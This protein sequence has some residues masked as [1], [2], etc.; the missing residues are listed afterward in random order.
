MKTYNNKPIFLLSLEDQDEGIFTISLVN[1]PAMELPLFCFNKETGY[2]F[3]IQDEM[4]HNIISCIA[5]VDYPILRVTE[6]GNPFYVLFN[7]E[8]T[9]SLCQKLMTNGF[10]QA[11]SLDHNGELIQ[12]IQLQEVFIKD[13][14]KGIN[15]IGYDDAADGSLFGIWH[16]T[17]DNLWNDCLS[18]KFGGV[19]LESTFRLEQ[20]S[21]KKIKNKFSMAN[22]IKEMLKNILMQFN[23]LSTNVADL[24]WEEDSELEVGMNVFVEDAEGN[25]QPAPD[26]EYISDENVI[27]VAEGKVTEI[28]EKEAEPAKEEPKND[29]PA[30][31]PAKEEMAEEDPKKEE[32]AQEEPQTEPEEN[33]DEKDAKIAELESRVADLESKL[34]ELVAKIAEIAQAP[35]AQPVVEEFENVTTPKT[36]GDKKLDKRIALAAALKD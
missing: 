19:S 27:K 4:K 30:Q 2:K 3:S 17:D 28:A 23:S 16:I 25:R 1:D 22:K 7:K 34:E 11:I 20:F 31:E 24:F 26:G 32:P 14:E 13:T 12:G 36:T 6:D 10:S 21:N 8:T 35:A 15:P 9:Q 33:K 29:E 18:G 5:R